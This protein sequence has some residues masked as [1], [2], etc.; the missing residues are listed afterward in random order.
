MNVIVNY[1]R[2]YKHVRV[3]FALPCGDPVAKYRDLRVP[4][5]LQVICLHVQSVTINA[6]IY[7]VVSQCCIFLDT[8]RIIVLFSSC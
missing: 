5:A 6:T 7:I 8:A 4:N 2:V 1:F 3:V